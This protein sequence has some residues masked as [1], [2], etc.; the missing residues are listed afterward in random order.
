[1]LTSFFPLMTTQFLMCNVIIYLNMHDTNAEDNK[2]DVLKWTCFKGILKDWKYIYAILSHCFYSPMYHKS[3]EKIKVSVVLRQYITFRFTKW[4]YL[5]YKEQ[6][7]PYLMLI[8]FYEGQHLTMKFHFWNFC[9][10]IFFFNFETS[11]IFNF[12]IVM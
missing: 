11:N 12:Y 2:R 10:Y 7:C 8:S 9:Y 1:M 4:H 3:C 6:T 5:N